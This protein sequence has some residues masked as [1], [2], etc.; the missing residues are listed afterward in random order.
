MKAVRLNGW[1]QPVQLEDIPQPSLASDEVLVRV[2]AASINPLDAFIQAGYLQFMLTAPLTMGTDF[3]GEVVAAGPEVTHVQPGDAV[4]GMVPF[5]SGTFA[6][7]TVA[8][9]NELAC[10]PTSMDYVQAAGVPLASMAAVQSLMELGH[11]QPG[12]RVLITGAGGCVGSTAVQMAKQLGMYVIA[13]AF[14]NKKE[15]IFGLGA[16]EFIDAKEMRFEEI[17]GEVDLV[18]DYVGGD[19]LQRTLQVI[20][21]GGRY[22][23]SQMLPP[24]PDEAAQRGIEVIGLA[25]QPRREQ[26]EALARQIDDGQLKIIID[27]TFTLDDVEEAFAYRYQKKDPG[28]VV[29]V[30]A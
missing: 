1:G 23:T 14:D 5:H 16:D 25:A 29:L 8:K 17:A 30:V 27:R 18:L 10:M 28:K 6:E 9:A 4:Y 3:A 21:P 2:H 13:V 11:G 15:Y 7:Y 20:K 22:V 24:V 12:Q 19:Y 26:L